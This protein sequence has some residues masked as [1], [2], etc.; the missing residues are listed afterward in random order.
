MRIVEI[1]LRALCLHQVDQ[2]QRRTFPKVID[3]GLVCEAQDQHLRALQTPP[4]LS[5]QRVGTF[6]GQRWPLHVSPDDSVLSFN[7]D[8][9]TGSPLG[10]GRISWIIGTDPPSESPQTQSFATDR[11]EDGKR[12]IATVFERPRLWENPPCP[13]IHSDP[14]FPDLAPGEEMVSRGRLFIYEGEDFQAEVARRV[15]AG[16]LL[17]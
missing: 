17:K 5:V 13:C 7:K 16:T 9:R 12:W 8:S 6:G 10:T 15:A 14:N 2:R 4:G 1:A 3:V 11:S